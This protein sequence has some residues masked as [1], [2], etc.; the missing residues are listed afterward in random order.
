MNSCKDNGYKQ[1]IGINSNSTGLSYKVDSLVIHKMNSYNIPGLAI[2]LVAQDSIIYTKGY[3]LTAITNP[4]PVTAHSNFHTASI[5]KLFT[6]QAIMLLAERNQINLDAKLIDLAPELEYNDKPSENITV[7]SLLNHTSGLPDVSNYHWA[8]NNQ[9]A[10]SLSEYIQNL[11]LKVKTEPTTKY[12]YSNLGYNLLGYVI[13][14]ASGGSF[15]AYVKDNILS[16][17]RMSNSDFRYFSILDSI[18]TAPHSKNR[19]TQKIYQRKTY[20]YTREHSPSSTLNSSTKD[21]SRWMLSFLESVDT[22][23]T[24]AAM[25]ESSFASYPHIGLGFQL[26]SLADKKTVGHYGGD[27]GYRSYLLMIPEE[28]LGLVLLANCDYN[29]DFR[30]EILHPIAKIMIADYQK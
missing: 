15:E 24:L 18:K 25:V 7:R 16:P 30:Q 22:S 20:P 26:N 21:L 4:N 9:S 27:R 28:D 12:H 13:E 8:K 10:G 17:S 23:E 11:K 5:S 1:Q 14:K 2:G 6:A 29:E 3:G 19:L